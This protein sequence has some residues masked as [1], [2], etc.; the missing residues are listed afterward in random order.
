MLALLTCASA[1]FGSHKAWMPLVELLDQWEYTKDFA[2][3]VGNRSGV[4]FKHERGSLTIDSRIGT[5]STSKW[6]MAMALT[7]LVADGTIASLDSLA[8]DYIPW[9]TK[10]ASDPRS[11]VT[12]RHLLSFTSGF[13]SGA[14]G[15]GESSGVKCEGD[16]DEEYEACSMMVYAYTPMWGKPGTVYSYNGVHLRLAMVMAMKASKLTLHEVLD[17]YL[18]KGLHMHHTTCDGF[19]NPSPNVS[20]PD[21]SAC[22]ITTGRDYANFLSGMLDYSLRPEP[23]IKASEQ[24]YTPFLQGYTLYG[25]YGFGHFLECFD[26]PAGMTQ[27]CRD[28][29]I[30]AD[31]GGFGYYPLIDRA[32]D[33]WMQIVAFES[34]D[35]YGYS[36][37]PEYL[38]LLV[39]P[40]V[41]AIMRGEDTRMGDRNRFNALSLADMNYIIQ[42]GNHPE[43]CL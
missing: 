13:G 15:G 6:P 4:V 38:R 18:V 40:Y 25:N 14:P 39:K 35:R 37:I 10:N 20:N 3:V 9:W 11:E 23:I 5:A 31:P 22:L 17:K 2:V 29:K 19:Q 16:E 28:A 34:G 32:N 33:F 12:L 43:T 36:G 27:K 24:D 26:N 21:L 8:S 41:D 30:H 42:C 1:A 7:G